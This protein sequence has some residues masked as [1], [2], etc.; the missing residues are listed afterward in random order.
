MRERPSLN[1]IVG[2]AAFAV[3]VGMWAMAFLV[4]ISMVHTATSIEDVVVGGLGVVLLAPIFALFVFPGAALNAF[5]LCLAASYLLSLTWQ[6]TIGRQRLT[7]L[8]LSIPL[9]AILGLLTLER[10]AILMATDMA[11][12]AALWVPAAALSMLAARSILFPS[13]W[14]GY[15]R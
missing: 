14:K 5:L 2:A 9:G 12:S 6:L 11:I 7:A 8:A 1:R 13:G 3:I 10:W 4:V 15:R